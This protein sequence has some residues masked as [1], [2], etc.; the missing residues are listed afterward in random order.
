MSGARERPNTGRLCALLYN[1]TFETVAVTS[2]AAILVGV[3][4]FFSG[5]PWQ[6][7]RIAIRRGL[8]EAC[9]FQNINY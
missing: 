8:H 1:F 9:A 3:E 4:A 5:V 2:P 6:P 7:D